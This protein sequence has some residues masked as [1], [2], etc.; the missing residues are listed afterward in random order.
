M[1]PPTRQGKASTF[2]SGKSQGLK[3]CGINKK[4]E[5]I[6]PNQ[7]AEKNQNDLIGNAQFNQC[8]KTRDIK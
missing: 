3:S 2:N 5:E 7:Q 6:S 1:S 8:D 4:D